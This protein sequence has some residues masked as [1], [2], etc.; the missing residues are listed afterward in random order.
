MSCISDWKQ[1]QTKVL[2]SAPHTAINRH[3]LILF[4]YCYA[5]T[6]TYISYQHLQTITNNCVQTVSRQSEDFTEV[7]SPD[8]E[9]DVRMC[10]C[11][12][13]VMCMCVCICVVCMLVIVY[14]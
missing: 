10:M 3:I 6:N 11:V 14:V 9:N 12:C 2:L 4:L 5:Y 13:M 7:L 8:P 1:V